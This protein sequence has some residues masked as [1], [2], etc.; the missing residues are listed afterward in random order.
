MQSSLSL[1]PP[2][3]V[4]VRS[5]LPLLALGK[6]IEFEEFVFPQKCWT[7]LLL[8]LDIAPPKA[9]K[10][11]LQD[12]PVTRFQGVKNLCSRDHNGAS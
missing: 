7:E 3:T 9:A 10:A 2:L 6:G 12:T 1:Y 4:H 8:P 11:N 5:S